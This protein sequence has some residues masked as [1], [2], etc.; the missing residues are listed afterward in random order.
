MISLQSALP[1]TFF[2]VSLHKNNLE[3][4][5]SLTTFFHYCLSLKP[6]FTSSSVSKTFNKMSINSESAYVWAQFEYDELLPGKDFVRIA[7]IIH[8]V[9]FKQQKVF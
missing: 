1:L 9:K 7:G 6:N 3:T 8:K 2:T 5:I 4:E